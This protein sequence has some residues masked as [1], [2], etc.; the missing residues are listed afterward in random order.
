MQK[1]QNHF[2]IRNYYSIFLKLHITILQVYFSDE[3]CQRAW[4]GLSQDA[5][6][7]RPGRGK[8]K[9]CKGG[10]P[11]R[12]FGKTYLKPQ[13]PLTVRIFT[14]ANPRYAG[15]L[16]DKQGDNTIVMMERVRK[17]ITASFNVELADESKWLWLT[18]E[19]LGFLLRQTGGGE[20]KKRKTRAKNG[21]NRIFDGVSPVAKFRVQTIDKVDEACTNADD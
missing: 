8:H 13:Q 16:N 17:A 2:V 7:S 9:A 3:G 11:S 12:N 4:Q 18:L 19:Q 6:G 14:N 5:T 20:H 21:E 1:I 10:G 15:K